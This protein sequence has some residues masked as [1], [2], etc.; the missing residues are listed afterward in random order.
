MLCLSD[1]DKL[2]MWGNYNTAHA[3]NL[4]VVF[5][6]CVTRTDEGA[7]CKS[8]AEINKWMARR[9]I[10]TYVNTRMLA[11][12]KFEGERI[13]KKTE[14]SWFSLNPST[15]TDNVIEIERQEYELQDNQWGYRGFLLEHE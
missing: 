4:M 9:Y 15:R 7:L 2:E 14:T 1:S 8:E 13:L 6:K 12:N 5:D 11:P 3:K 10:M